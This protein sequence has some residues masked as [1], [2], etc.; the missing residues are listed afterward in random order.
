MIEND[1]SLE[2]L[3]TLTGYIKGYLDSLKETIEID[4]L[5]LMEQL[6]NTIN[7]EQK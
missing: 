2:I 6:S 4:L 1:I 7:K 5:K 3:P